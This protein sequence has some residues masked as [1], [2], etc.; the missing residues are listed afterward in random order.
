MFRFVVFFG[1][2]DVPPEDAVPLA[3]PPTA[4]LASTVS[5][6]ESIFDMTSPFRHGYRVE[7]LT[8]NAGWCDADDAHADAAD[9]DLLETQSTRWASRRAERREVLVAATRGGQ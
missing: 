8:T 7:V 1:S 2:P 3:S 9:W 5:L 4:T 6:V